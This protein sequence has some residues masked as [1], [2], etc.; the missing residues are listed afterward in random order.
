MATVLGA[1]LAL[2]PLRGGTPNRSPAVLETQIVLA[3]IGAVIMLVVGTS[4]A[5]AF[6]IVGVASLIRYRSKIDDPKDAVVMLSALSVGLAT[7][8]G[9]FALAIFST[10][11]LVGV[12]WVIEG[13]ETQGRVFELS[14]K[15]GDKTADYRPK[16]EA[17]LRRFDAEFELRASSEKE[18]TYLVMAPLELKTNRVSNVLMALAPDGEGAVEWKQKPKVEIKLKTGPTEKP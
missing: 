11:F 12:L 16:I 6:G 14:L 3:I 8:A 9:H 17:V 10:L 15:L 2:R 7:G 18:V 13:F 1:A 4:L 5:R